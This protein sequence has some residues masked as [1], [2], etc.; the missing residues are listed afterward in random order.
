MIKK[1]Y[2]KMKES[3]IFGLYGRIGRSIKKV[4]GAWKDIDGEDILDIDGN[5]ILITGEQQD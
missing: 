4:T 5:R 3:T 1:I 2:G